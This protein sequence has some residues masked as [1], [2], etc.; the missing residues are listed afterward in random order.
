MFNEYLEGYNQEERQFIIKGFSE[1]FPLGV[2]GSVPS[3]ISPNHS[4]ALTHQDFI[5]DKL[6][7]ELRLNRIKGPFPSPPFDNFKV[8]PLGVVPKREPNS[9]RLIQDLSFGPQGSAV[10]HFIP[11]ENATVSLETFDH[12]ANLVVECGRNSLIS[13]ADVEEAYRIV[14]LSPLEYPRLGFAW[15]GQFYF[16]RVLVMGASSSVKIFESIAKSIQW[17]LQSKLGVEH[18]SHIIDDFIFIGKGGTSECAE[19]LQKFFDLCKEM[20]IPIKLKKTV[21]PT[22]CAPIHGIDLDTV[23]MEARLPD[24]KLSALKVLLQDNIHRK[25]IKFKDLQ[26]LLGHL[27]F[28]CRVIKPGRCFLRR[29]YDLTCGTHKPD[30]FIRLN[31]AARADLEVWYSFLCQYNGCTIITDDRFISSNTL[32]L[33]TDAA[34]SKGFACIFREF[35]AWG[36]FS[37][38]VKQFHINVLELYPITL[39]VYLFGS[40]WQ[41]KNILLICDNLSIVHCLNN[42]TSKDKTVMR[43]LRIIVLESLKFNFCFASKHISSKSNIICD[44]LSRFQ[45]AEAKALAKHLK[46]EP[47]KIPPEVSPD[48]MLL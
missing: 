4:S 12:V 28:A 6:R 8:S 26:S 13:K 32:Q 40:F 24:D 42:Q 22:T 5:E 21:F 20:G 17:I 27:N 30:H 34:R 38:S 39:A 45:I 19:S 7:K 36:A 2:V 46:E 33:H 1:G 37:V 16:E 11:S 29:L 25:K 9:F 15:K 14:P 44:K 43:M 10:N 48:S 31:N 3:S 18:V 35:W 47:E 23:K 41:N